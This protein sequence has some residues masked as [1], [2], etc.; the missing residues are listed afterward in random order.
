MLTR[1]LTLVTILT[2]FTPVPTPAQERFSFFQA[3]TPESVDRMLT[4]AGLRD[5]DVVVDLGSGDGLIPLTA[6]R[7]NPRLRGWGVD[8]DAKL[9]HEANARARSQGVADRIRFEHRNAFDADLR[10]ATVVTMWLFPEL[11]RLLRPVILERARPGTRVLTSTWDLGS[12]KPDKVSENG[13]IYMWIVPARVGGSWEWSLTVSGRR[14]RYAS[15]IEQHFQ[16]IEGVARAGDRREVLDAMTLSGEDIAFTLNITLD[17]LGLTRHEFSGKV[18][19]NQIVGTVKVTPSGQPTITLPWR[20]RR[21][22]RSYYFAPTGT[23]MFRPT[24]RSR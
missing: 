17:G 19:E 18:R 5:D 4:L 7:M 1:L 3:S 8:I 15:V 22:E 6:A 9:V 12:W 16:V 11:M 23:S 20:A 10:E 21:S 13:P 14:C 2:T 24:D